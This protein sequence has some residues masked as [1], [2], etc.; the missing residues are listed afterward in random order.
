MWSFLKSKTIE[1][2]YILERIEG[3]SEDEQI[4]NLVI[5]DMEGDFDG[6]VWADMY[7]EEHCAKTKFKIIYSDGSSKIEIVKD[8]SRKYR[9]YIQYVD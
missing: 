5:G 1:K 6:L 7:N 8:G 4:D 9:K 3:L 2:V